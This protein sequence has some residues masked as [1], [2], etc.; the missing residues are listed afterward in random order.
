MTAHMDSY[1]EWLWYVTGSGGGSAEG[2]PCGPCGL[3]AISE[4]SR[5]GIA[6]LKIA[7]REG[8]AMRKLISLRLVKAVVDLVRHGASPE[9]VAARARRMRNTPQMCDTG[10]MCYY[11]NHA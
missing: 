9:E 2:L 8:S 5:M 7:G 4:L 3:C 1:R 11:R 10:Y 6:A